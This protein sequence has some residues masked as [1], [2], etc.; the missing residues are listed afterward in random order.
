[1][2]ET[3]AWVAKAAIAEL[4]TRYA[5]LNDAGDWDGVAALYTDDGRMSRPTAPDDFIAGRAAILA[6]FRSRPPRAARHIIANV[7]VT[8]E[9]ETEARATSQ[10]LLFTAAST[11]EGLPIQSTPPLV[12]SYRDRLTSTHQGWRF[13]ERRGSLDFRA[14]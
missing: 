2:N 7:L 9:S 3:N 11:G 12:G 13:L 4:I 10:I 6:A 5:A 8:L 14:P 1:M